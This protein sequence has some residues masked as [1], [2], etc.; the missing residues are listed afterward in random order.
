MNSRDLTKRV[1]KAFSPC[2]G[3]QHQPQN[4]S[5]PVASAG[6]QL[7][8]VVRSLVGRARLRTWIAAYELEESRQLHAGAQR[9]LRSA[10]CC[11]G[12]SAL[13]LLRGAF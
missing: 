10:W 13:R 1:A 3:T 9:Y 5:E 2:S 7:P 4:H 6:H 11:V 8:M 12:L